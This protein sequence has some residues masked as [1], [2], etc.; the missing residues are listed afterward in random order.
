MQYSYFLVYKIGA[1]EILGQNPKPEENVAQKPVRCN[2]SNRAKQVLL[3]AI[4]P[5]ICTLVYKCK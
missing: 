1:R 3:Y 4:I 2:V 5:P